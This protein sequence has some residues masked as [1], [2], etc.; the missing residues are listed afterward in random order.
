LKSA[1][2]HVTDKKIYVLLAE[3]DPLIG[4]A[5]YFGPSST[6]RV[7]RF[8]VQYILLLEFPAASNK[9]TFIERRL[10]KFFS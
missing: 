7:F 2:V 6:G 9:P 10:K 1:E 4:R 8:F 5:P 3:S